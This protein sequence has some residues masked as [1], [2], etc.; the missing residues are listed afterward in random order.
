M[1]HNKQAVDF[2]SLQLPAVFSNHFQIVKVSA[3]LVRLSFGEA[4]APDQPVYRSAILMTLDDA[5]LLVEGLAHVL[6]PKTAA[7]KS[8]V[9]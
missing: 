5:R 9:N 4:P 8:P 3:S 7:A 2:A 6:T 1:A